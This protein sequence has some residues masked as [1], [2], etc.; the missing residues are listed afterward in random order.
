MG[1]RVTEILGIQ[2]PVVQAPLV[3]LTDAKLTAA[4]SNAGGL[5]TLGPYAGLWKSESDGETLRELFREQVKEVKALASKPFAANYI[6]GEP[7]VP[8]TKLFAQILGEV[9][10][11]EHVPVVCFCSITAADVQS[12]AIQTFKEAGIKVIYR[13]LSPSVEKALLAQNVGVD[14]YVATGR[15]SGGS[16]SFN[17]ISTLV[18]LPQVVDALDIPVMAAGGLTSTKSAAAVKATG[19]EGV[20]AGT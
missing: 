1:N 3:W 9:I 10:L 12:E 20:Y 7:T 19:A 11:S 4:V 8:V 13:D 2:H 15:E 14:I 6:G 5:G 18:I 16:L 17:H